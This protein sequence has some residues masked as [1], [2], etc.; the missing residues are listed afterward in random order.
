MKKKTIIKR[1]GDQGKEMDIAAQGD[2]SFSSAMDVL[3]GFPIVALIVEVAN[4][5]SKLAALMP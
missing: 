5:N 2:E 4:S 1:R 3:S